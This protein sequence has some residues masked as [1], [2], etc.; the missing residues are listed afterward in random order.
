MADPSQL[1]LPIASRGEPILQQRAQEVADPHDP[2]IQTLIDAMLATMLA[3]NGIGIAAPQVFVS[4]RII[5]VASRPNPRYP[6]AP[7]MEPVAMLNPEILWQSA[8]MVTD[9]E[10]CL[11]VPDARSPVPRAAELRVRYLTRYG[12]T[13]EANYEGFVA[14]IIQHECD[15]L[16][17]VLFVERVENESSIVSESVFLKMTAA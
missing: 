11:S 5:I 3:A 8:D 13:V 17:G 6:D 10:G 9:W 16:D 7:L 14:R 15:H 4:I 1:L 12:E 2:D